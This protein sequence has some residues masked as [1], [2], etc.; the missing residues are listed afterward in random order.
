[1]GPYGPLQA[2]NIM[3]KIA[4]TLIKLY[5]QYIS[6]YIRKN[7]RF[8]PTCS[9]YTFVSIEKFGL[10]KGIFLGLRRIGRCHPWSA[11]GFDPVQNT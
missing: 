7:C 8:Y 6:P 3:K 2:L 11:G 5:Q 1:M 9:E 4:L 10:V